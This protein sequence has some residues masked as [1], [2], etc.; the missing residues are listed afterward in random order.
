MNL[1]EMEDR[2]A[3]TRRGKFEAKI[4]AIVFVLL[5]IVIV[6]IVGRSMMMG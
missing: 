3:R 5:L 4:W 2:A 1:T 6:L